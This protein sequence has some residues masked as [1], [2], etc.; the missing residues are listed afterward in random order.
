MISVL[1]SIWLPRLIIRLTENIPIFLLLAILLLM[2]SGLS[3]KASDEA[4]I[5]YFA[6]FTAARFAHTICY[7]LAIPKIRGVC[8]AI[9]V[10]A[11]LAVAIHLLIQVFTPISL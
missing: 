5:V 11:T 8:W 6:V 3:K 9:G 1:R 7:M 4:H 2:T 10:L